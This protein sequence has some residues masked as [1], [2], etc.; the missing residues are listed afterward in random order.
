ME[1]QGGGSKSVQ[2]RRK[3]ATTKIGRTSTEHLF[4]KHLSQILRNQFGTEQPAEI[5]RKSNEHQININ[6]ESNPC[7][8]CPAPY[9]RCVA[10]AQHDRFP[11]RW[12]RID[13]K[14]QGSLG[15]DSQWRLL[16][17]RIPRSRYFVCV[18]SIF[19]IHA[20]NIIASTCFKHFVTA[21]PGNP[22]RGWRRRWKSEA[23]KDEGEVKSLWQSEAW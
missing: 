19:S 5:N 22:R 8:G 15:C 16:M 6:R 20:I 23:T 21:T 10:A 1:T 11:A 18:F 3:E 12:S 13:S 7:R 4:I 9:Y 14:A 17:V 2:V